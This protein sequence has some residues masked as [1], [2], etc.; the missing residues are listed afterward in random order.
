MNSH[1]LARLILAGPDLPVELKVEGTVDGSWDAFW[2]DLATVETT[3]GKLRLTAA[4]PDDESED[5][6]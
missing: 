2:G 4:L 5:E 1:E 3:E 6:E